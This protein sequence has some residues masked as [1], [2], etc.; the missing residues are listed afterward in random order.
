MHILVPAIPGLDPGIVLPGQDYHSDQRPGP[1]RLGRPAAQGHIT[2][3]EETYSWTAEYRDGI[4]AGWWRPE[5]RKSY[6]PNRSAGRFDH[7]ISSGR[8]HLGSSSERTRREL[9]TR[10]IYLLRHCR[11][12]GSLRVCHEKRG[13]SGDVGPSPRRLRS[14]SR[15]PIGGPYNPYAGPIVRLYSASEGAQ[16]HH[17]ILGTGNRSS[18]LAWRSRRQSERR[19]L[20]AAAQSRMDRKEARGHS[21]NLA[22]SQK[23]HASS[24]Y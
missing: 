23:Q 20:V 10:Q 1:G 14:K 22:D 2:L 19:P 4:Y 9:R 6:L 11:V 5:G 3:L 12:R 21:L 15:R 18:A 24:L 7:G 17:R 16:I 8:L 13:Q